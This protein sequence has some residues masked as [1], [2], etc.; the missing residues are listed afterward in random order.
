VPTGQVLWYNS[1]KGY[2]FI[3]PDDGPQDIVVQKG[4]VAVAGLKNLVAG[5]TVSYDLTT[6]D[7]NVR[8]V[9][10]KLAIVSRWE[11]ATRGSACAENGQ[12]FSK[13]A[14]ERGIDL[15]TATP[16]TGDA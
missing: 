16:E 4:D 2:G 8:A 10:L 11:K 13:I 12:T 9:N 14:E 7:D 15:E 3:R 6:I 1:S 5:E